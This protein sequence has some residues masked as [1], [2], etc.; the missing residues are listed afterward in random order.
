MITRYD[1]WH[2]IWY[3]FR[4]PRGNEASLCKAELKCQLYISLG[5]GG[6]GGLSGTLKS[7]V[8]I[9]ISFWGAG[10]GGVV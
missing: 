5:G 3:T 4:S 7:E 10:G 1:T 2:M 6:G 8:K 9:F